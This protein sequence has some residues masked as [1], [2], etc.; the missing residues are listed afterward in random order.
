MSLR[1]RFLLYLA[2]IHLI[3]AGVAWLAL[4]DHRLWLIMAEAVFVLSLTVGSLL[5]RAYSA[6]LKFLRA[7]VAYLEEADLSTRF[8]EHG[9]PE[10][11]ALIRTY[12]R[13]IDNLRE[14]RIRNREQEFFL[15]DVLEASTAGVITMDFDG[16]ILSANPSGAV[17]LGKPADELRGRNLTEIGSAFAAQLSALEGGDPRV[18]RLRGRRR[19]RCQKLA[20]MDRGFPRPFFLLE[21]LTEELHRTEKIAYGKLIRMMSHEVNNTVGAV[22]SLLQSCGTFAEQLRDSDREDFEKALAVAISRGRHMN[23]FMQSF[24]EVV[25]L[26]EP[27]LVPCNVGD[28][29]ADVL[30]LMHEQLSRHA[31][32][33]RWEREEAA[34]VLVLDAAQMEQV[35]INVIKNAI[36]A[37]GSTGTIT[38]RLAGHEGRP[39]LAIRD[40]GAGISPE[41]QENLFTPFYTTKDDGQGIGLTLVQEILLHHGFDFTL[42][43]VSGGGAEFT[44]FFS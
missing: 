27:R 33:V 21:E 4:R 38:I 32:D 26:P 41:V 18:L 14:E 8:A 10:M 5:V 2:G 40:S 19:V 34:V 7:G 24:A 31:I 22:N 15:K 17:L 44:I 16:R 1:T 12:N 3:L 39:Y 11:R 25:R 42:N 20:F 6:P 43:N 36:D 29:L 28:L 35:L 9:S 23:E 30:R 13:M 37:I